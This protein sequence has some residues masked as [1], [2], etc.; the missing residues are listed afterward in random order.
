MDL[1][2]G[3]NLVI[4]SK[5]RTFLLGCGL[6]VFGIFLSLILVRTRQTFLLV[7]YILTLFLLFLFSWLGKDFRA[8]VVIIFLLLFML[9]FL[10]GVW[11]M[12]NLDSNHTVNLV[13]KKMSVVGI[14][15]DVQ[16]S[17]DGVTYI[18]KPDDYQGNII[19]QSALYPRYVYGDKIKM[20]CQFDFPDDTAGYARYLSTRNIFATCNFG[21]LVKTGAGGGNFLGKI[22]FNWQESLN[23][24]ISSL[25]P[26]PQAS[27]MAGILYGERGNMSK[28]VKDSF[29]NSGL[30][31]IIAVSGYNTSIIALI[32]MAVFIFIGCWRKQ[33]FWLSSGSLV[34]FTLF[35]GATASVVRA[36]VMSIFVMLGSYWGRSARMLNS[37]MLAA[38]LMLLLN[39]KVLFDVGFQLSFVATIGVAYVGPI[40]TSYFIGNKDLN[41]IKKT[42]LELFFTTCGAMTVTLPLTIF[43]FGRM[44]VLALLANILVVGFIPVIML[45][46]FLALLVSFLIFPLGLLIA[47]AADLGLRYIILVSRLCAVGSVTFSFPFVIMLLIYGVIFYWLYRLNLYVQKS[48]N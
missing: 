26:E 29:S 47:F 22:L 39:P 11:A 40:L 41:G 42:V 10:R 12:P 3:F 20:L 25:W 23:S 15:T 43:Y 6:F 7:S 44:P 31:H 33:A 2:G 45:L 14:I 28:E 35:T 34:L 5:S 13:G 16:V 24:K 18:V 36:A 46:G 48:K 21:K 37:L 30:S 19:L 8:R 27:L 1:K 38:T 9:G 32:V 17:V 4:N